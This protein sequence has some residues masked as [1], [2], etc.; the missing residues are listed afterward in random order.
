MFTQRESEIIDFIKNRGKCSSKEVFDNI[1]SELSYATLK[2]ILT[3][4]VA[5]N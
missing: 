3:K 2:R 5:K 1:I 4:L